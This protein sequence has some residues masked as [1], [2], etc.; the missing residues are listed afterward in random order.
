[1]NKITSLILPLILLFMAAC[2]QEES[3][4]VDDGKKGKKQVPVSIVLPGSQTHT[5]TR[6][7][8]TEIGSEQENKITALYLTLKFENEV[9]KKDIVGEE[10][11]GLLANKGAIDEN[12]NPMLEVTCD[13]DFNVWSSST[14]I[15]A[16]VFANSKDEPTPIIGED[17]LWKDGSLFMSGRSATMD[18]I[19]GKVDL[20]R[21]VAKLRTKVGKTDD[22]IP[23]NLQIKYKEIKVEVLNVADRSASLPDSTITGVQFISY[24]ERNARNT[25]ET[26]DYPSSML[27]DSCYIH[28]NKSATVTTLNIQ[29]PTYDPLTGHTVVLEKDYSIKGIKDHE[30]E[31]N[32]IYTLDIKIRSQKEPLEIFLDVQPWRIEDINVPNLEPVPVAN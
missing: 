12:G 1:M 32:H 3:L 18:K 19:G 22:C 11:V 23:T 2:S 5:Q 15:D 6:S 30:I 8:A 7:G 24:A 13:V 10:L 26:G 9:V 27:V 17:G 28:E 21:Q 4:S 14:T 29:I 20:V 31:R 25:I 16:T